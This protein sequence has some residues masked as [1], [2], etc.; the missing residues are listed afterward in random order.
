MH[1]QIE[2]IRKEL[3]AAGERLHSL[4]GA[5]PAGSWSRRPA[6][7]SWSIA[8]CVQHLNLTSA[9]FVPRLRAAVEEARALDGPAPRRYRRDP[10]GSLL[11]RMMAPPVRMRTKTGASFVPAADADP[12]ALIR[13]FDRLQAEQIAIVDS[14]D[15]LPLSRV[16][17][18]SPFDPRVRYNLFAALGILS[19][20]Q[21]RHLWQAERAL[22]DVRS[23]ER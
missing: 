10:I 1:P 20:H 8:E 12:A 2:E 17:I 5:V 18:E 15:R 21:H 9:E 6:P 4:A 14:S 11:W 13:E 7:G 3:R 16:R 22:A 23:T 19:R